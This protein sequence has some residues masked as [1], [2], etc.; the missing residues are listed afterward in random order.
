[1]APYISL[2][3]FASLAKKMPEGAE[4]FSVLPGTTVGDVLSSFGI[5]ENEAKLVFI[6]HKRAE[7]SNVLNDGDRLGVFP[8]VGGG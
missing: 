7:L 4:R 6:N 5:S 1:M 8:P 3:F 2:K